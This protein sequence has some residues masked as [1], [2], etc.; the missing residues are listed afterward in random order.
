MVAPGAGRREACGV[1]H[2]AQ[3]DFPLS[4]RLMESERGG[5]ARDS[6]RPVLEMGLLFWREIIVFSGGGGPPVFACQPGAGDMFA[7]LSDFFVAPSLGL[8]RRLNRRV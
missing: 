4:V 7:N 1:L 5:H 8:G 2:A 6:L 3:N